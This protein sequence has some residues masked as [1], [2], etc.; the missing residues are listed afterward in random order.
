MCALTRL[1]LDDLL[2]FTVPESNIFRSLIVELS[3]INFIVVCIDIFVGSVVPA[4]HL[5]ELG[6]VI[7]GFIV[8]GI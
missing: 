4:N 8:S 2:Y 6:L 7:V 5:N 1:L 3:H